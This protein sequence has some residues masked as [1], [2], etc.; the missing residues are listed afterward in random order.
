VGAVVAGSIGV[1]VLAV[2]ALAAAALADGDLLGARHE[3]AGVACAGCHA[4]QPPARAVE[5]PTCLT[6]H[7]DRA[8][9]AQ[10]TAKAVL[11]P[12]ASPH[13]TATAASCTTCHH[14]HRRSQNTCATCH[15]DA[16]ARVP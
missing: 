4:E 16:V 14:A 11:N 3:A 6:C 7:A 9:L 5:G 8:A 13:E 10:R 1:A 12:H 15:E 2:V